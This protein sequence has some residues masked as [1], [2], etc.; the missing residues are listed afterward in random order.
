MISRKPV[1]LFDADDVLENL[2]ECWVKLL[3]R[4]YGTSVEPNDVRSWN[5]NEA[6]PSLTREQVYEPLVEDELWESLSPIPGSQ[7]IL[8]KLHEEKFEIYIV[9]ATDYRNCRVKFDRLK[10]MFPFIDDK[11]LIVA[12]NKQMVIGD[13]LVDDNPVNLVGGTYYGILFDRPHNRTFDAKGSG[14]IRVHNFDEVYA[15]IKYRACQFELLP[16]KKE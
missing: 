5:V 3:N 13:I 7:K 6:F 15:A 1:I 4:R 8:N 11:H 9:T 12:H 16:K 2:L 10:E 14:M